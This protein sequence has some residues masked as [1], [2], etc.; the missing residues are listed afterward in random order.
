MIDE[1]NAQIKDAMKNQKRERLEALRFIKAKLLENKTSKA[2]TDEQS[3][4]IAHYKQLKDA[5]E[6]Y[7]KDGEHYRKIEGEISVVMVW[8][9]RCPGR[10]SGDGTSASSIAPLRRCCKTCFTRG[11]RYSRKSIVNPVREQP[12]T[13]VHWRMR[14]TSDQSG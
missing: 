10:T 6:A 5:L 3:V 9:N 2:P 8:I 4:V 13:P 11:L 1:I 12:L 7:P 14:S